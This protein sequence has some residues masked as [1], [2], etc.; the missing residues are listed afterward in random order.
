[1]LHPRV[2]GRLDFVQ[3]WWANR[4]NSDYV[5][6]TAHHES[7]PYDTAVTII[8]YRPS[9]T[10]LPQWQT[11]LVWSDIYQ[12]FVFQPRIKAV[13]ETPRRATREGAEGESA[14]HVASFIRIVGFLYR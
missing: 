14:R 6:T 3:Y 1:M 9:D 13:V 10:R 4:P 11:A 12:D 7:G 2:V 8:V 5:N